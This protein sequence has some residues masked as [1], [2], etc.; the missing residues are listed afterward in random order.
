MNICLMKYD[1]SSSLTE[2]VVS[3]N[4]FSNIF[5]LEV[6]FL[7]FFFE[8]FFLHDISNQIQCTT[9]NLQRVII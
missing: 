1:N 2:L 3:N 4:K 5:Y 9:S 7:F 8:A 6:I